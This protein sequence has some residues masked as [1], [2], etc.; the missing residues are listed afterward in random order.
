MQLMHALLHEKCRD[1][2]RIGQGINVIFQ[3]SMIYQRA[4]LTE[5]Q[6]HVQSNIDSQNWS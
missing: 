1:L 6:L 5:L 4:E 2:I 3:Q